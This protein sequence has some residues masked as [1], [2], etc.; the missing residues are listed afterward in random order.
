M[1]WEKIINTMP[2]DLN[3]FVN[4]QLSAKNLYKAAIAK[5]I[6]AEV[7]PLDR[8]CANRGRKIARAALR[9]RNL[10]DV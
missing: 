1:N 9:R 5:G 8:S 6:G 10:L 3:L 7:R 4:N 2:V